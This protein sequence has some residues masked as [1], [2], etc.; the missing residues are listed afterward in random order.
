MAEYIESEIMELKERYMDSICKEIV[1]FLNSDGGQI[2]IGVKDNGEIII[3]EKQ[4]EYSNNYNS[5][6]LITIQRLS[7]LLF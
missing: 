1:A 6:K 4:H 2:V 3:G 5:E 7:F